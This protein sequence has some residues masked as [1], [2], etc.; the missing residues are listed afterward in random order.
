MTTPKPLPYEYAVMQQQ[1]A[2]L[3][4]ILVALCVG[5]PTGEVISACCELVCRSIVAISR[6]EGGSYAAR[7]LRDAFV[8][9]LQELE[10]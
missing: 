1:A 7:T 10:L 4:D 6:A 8:E 9:T 2:E 3:F 5:H